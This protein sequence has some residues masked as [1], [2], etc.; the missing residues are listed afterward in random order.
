MKIKMVV[1]AIIL[2]ILLIVPATSYQI[3]MANNSHRQSESDAV[4]AASNGN[5]L[6]VGGSG[7]NNYTKIQ[8]AIDDASDG[9]TIFVYDDSSPYYE[10]IDI[11]KSVN[12][13]GEDKNTTIIDGMEKG[14]VIHVRANGTTVI[15]FTIQHGGGQPGAGIFVYSS[16]NIISSNIIKNN[17][18]GIVLMD[19]ASE[20]NEVS[21]NVVVNNTWEGID[22]FNA[23][24]NIVRRNVVSYN[25]GD[26][27]TIADAGSNT[28][29]K[30]VLADTIYLGR[31]YRNTV[32]D[33][34]FT[35]SG[36]R[37]WYSSD[38]KLPNNTIN[39][40][41]I[42]YLESKTDIEI[43][44]GTQVILVGC[45]RITIKNLNISNTCCAVH[46]LFCNECA[47][48]ENILE[49]N[50]YGIEMYSCK[51]NLIEKN[52]IF[53]SAHD[54]V[55]LWDSYGNSLKRNIFKNNRR[56]VSLAIG[57]SMNKIFSNNFVENEMHAIFYSSFHNLWL[58]NYWD[59]WKLP[60]PKP[61]SGT[62]F[63]FPWIQFDWIPCLKPY[64]DGGRK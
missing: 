43:N 13:I 18:E 14:D 40:E 19:L 10:N 51:K 44:E 33:N 9:D 49:S 60:L 52:K 42:V 1:L 2:S 28:I 5:T 46:L 29:E 62:F 41:A 4:T 31:A 39:G 54:G 48:E 26:G 37:I 50:S 45:E 53:N 61:I 12:L 57:S 63:G 32:R 23:Y 25:G 6:Y 24:K 7:P 3:D 56:G 35:E 36:I 8:D 64:E 17:V 38:N 16:S 27:I 34:S 59:N 20:Y 15:G 11:N 47:V 21:K 58:L 55:S 30:N 22:L